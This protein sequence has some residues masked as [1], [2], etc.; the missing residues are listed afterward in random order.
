MYTE[1][2]LLDNRSQMKR[3]LLLLAIPVLLC[4]IGIVITFIVRTKDFSMEWLTILLTIVGGVIVL[5]CYS[6]FIGPVRAY[7]KHIQNMLSG[8][9]REAEGYL[10]SFDRDTVWR[11]GV[12]YHPLMVNI[13]ERNDEE[14]NRL[15]YYDANRP[16]PAFDLGD[17]VH[18]VA[19]DKAVSAFR[20]M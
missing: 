19:H 11:D 18:V 1:Q 3:R 9:K 17:R 2:D 16:L 15:F 5:F 4:I 7:G 12:E 14:D 20:V 8:R 10:I 13:G 6:M